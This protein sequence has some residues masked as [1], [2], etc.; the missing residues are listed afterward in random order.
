MR[1]LADNPSMDFLRREAKDLLSALRESNATATLADAQRTIAEE[2]G[3]RTWSDLKTEVDRRRE[4]FPEPPEGLAQAV[5]DAFGLGAVTAPMTPIRYEYMGR[6]WQLETE[7]GR[8]MLSPVFDWINDEQA[9]V[10]VDLQQRARA[11]GVLSPRPVRA[12]DGG[13]VRRVLDQSWRVD[14]WMD[15]GPVPVQPVHS[16]VARRAGELL[17]AVHSV[18]PKTDRP[19]Q[20]QWV[21]ADARPTEDAWRTLL[22]L[23]RDAHKPWADELAALA[24]SIEELTTITAE[25]SP[26]SVVI[27][28]CD[29]V[30]EAVRLGPQQELVVLHWDFSGPMVPEWELASTLLQW[31]TSDHNTEAGR[32]FL[33]GY[34]ARSGNTPSLTLGSFTTAITGWLTWTLHRGWEACSPQPPEKE[35]FAERAVREALADPL[36]VGKLESFLQALQPVSS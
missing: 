2:Y 6:R 5:A 25:A 32:A 20:G 26:D 34:R 15:L 9:E 12:P 21:A 23:A 10:A 30:V 35:E 11:A 17:A 29:I 22:E 36:S 14:D 24:R 27:S 3:F 13:L 31:T 7:R 19:I 28:N 1:I 18:A 8:L 16:S 4:A 33:E